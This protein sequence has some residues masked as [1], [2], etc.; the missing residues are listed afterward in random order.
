[1]F[2]KGQNGKCL[3]SEF[4]DIAKEVKMKPVDH[5]YTVCHGNNCKYLCDSLTGLSSP[6]IVINQPQY[7]IYLVLMVTVSLLTVYSWLYLSYVCL[8]H[9]AGSRAK[10]YRNLYAS[11]LTIMIVHFL[12]WQNVLLYIG[13]VSNKSFVWCCIMGFFLSNL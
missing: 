2:I 10:I 8:D 13:R 4:P 7:L 12:A 11:I 1:M 6:H 5:G 3:P 9:V